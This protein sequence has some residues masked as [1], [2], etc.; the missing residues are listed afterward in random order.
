MRLELWQLCLVLIPG[1][2]LLHLRVAP[3]T[4]VEESFNIQ[5]AHD[6]LTYGISFRNAAA[7]IDAFYDHVKF[8]GPVPRTFIGAM[9]LAGLSN[10]FVISLG[11]TLA[12]QQSMGEQICVPYI[13]RLLADQTVSAGH[14]GSPQC[15]L[16]PLLC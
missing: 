5:A 8:P 15:V 10:P 6:F 4:K 2:V 16:N 9:G 12:Q 3:Y 7:R 1:L 14:A 11:L 13:K